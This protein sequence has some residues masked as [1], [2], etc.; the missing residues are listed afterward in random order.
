M[1]NRKKPI[2]IRMCIVCR[3]RF[4]QKELIRL[5]F[6]KETKEIVEFKGSG[7][8]FYICKKCL[9]EDKIIKVLTKNLHL[10]KDKS[11]N[12][13]EYLKGLYG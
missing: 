5:H 11:K 7:R 12:V 1:G 9:K 8:S 3:K 2:K 10:T 4:F 13:V 6:I